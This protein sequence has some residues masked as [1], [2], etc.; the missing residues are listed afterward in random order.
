MK[1]SI[2]LSACLN[3]LLMILTVTILVSCTKQNTQLPIPVASAGKDITITAPQDSVE[4]N[5]SGTVAMGTIVSYE[6]TQTAGPSQTVLA[7]KNNPSTIVRKLSIP[8]L[9]TIELKVTDNDGLSARDTVTVNVLPIG[10]QSCNG[11]WDY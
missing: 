8:G 2:K 11:C 5:G 7:N 9:Y 6:W 10:S 4:L 3:L 1:K